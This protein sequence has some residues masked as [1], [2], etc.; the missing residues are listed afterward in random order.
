MK[1][2]GKARLG[3]AWVT[4]PSLNHCERSHDIADFPSVDRS[5][6]FNQTVWDMSPRGIMVT[7]NRGKKGVTCKAKIAHSCYVLE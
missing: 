1:A 4:C 2:P 7:F 5:S 3:P 6:S